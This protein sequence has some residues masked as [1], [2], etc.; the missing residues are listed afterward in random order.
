[1]ARY[2]AYIK[3]YFFST[4]C[5][6]LIGVGVAF[7]FIM[8]NYPFEYDEIYTSLTADPSTPLPFI[9]KHYL[10]QDMHP[11]LHNIFLWFYN[12]I[13]PYGPEWILRLPSLA[14]SLLSLGLAWCLF[15]VRY[16][17]TARYLFVALC[18]TNFFTIFYAEQ[19][20]SYAFLFLEAVLLLLLLLR[21]LPRLAH[22]REIARKYWAVYTVLLILLMWT[23]YLGALVAVV[24][25]AVWF[26]MACYYRRYRWTSLLLPA[27]ALALFAIW[28]VPN[29]FANRALNRFNGA[30]WGN[31]IAPKNFI[32]ILTALF[33]KNK[34]VY[35]GFVVLWTLG[36]G[37]V[38]YQFR[39]LRLRMPFGRDWLF[40]GSVVAGVLAAAAVLFAVF[41]MS[42]FIS[43][44]F[45]GMLPFLYMF[46]TLCVVAFVRRFWV[47]QIAFVGL[48]AWGLS[49]TFIM[50]YNC[51]NTHG[52]LAKATSK[53]IQKYAP[54]KKLY[55]ITNV[56]FPVDSMEA[57]YGFY[58][59]RRMG[60]HMPVFELWKR[61]LPQREFLLATRQNAV[62][63]VPKCSRPFLNWVAQSWQRQVGVELVIHHA[64][65][66]IQLADRG[67]SLEPPVVFLPKQTPSLTSTKK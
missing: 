54:D 37:Y 4:A 20:R 17:K 33:V 60:M 40:L 1:M 32:P 12:H 6:L 59:N 36:L 63:W 61:P 38:Y 35:G 23:H 10:M 43:R 44:Y 28:L 25:A 9:M 27:G 51:K 29:F 65:C 30:W 58:L 31:S 34:Q 8:M 39:R 64:G 2:L 42:F 15:P 55:V 66:I 53:I 18:S 19:A 47:A 46:F 67:Y 21:M 7:R 56:S 52:F 11:P 14:A 57:L 50:V 22:K 45:T 16:G 49:S 41:H 3:K 62:I 26:A 48:V 24:V 13:V 5:L